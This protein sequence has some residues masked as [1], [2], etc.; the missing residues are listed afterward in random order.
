MLT[1]LHPA[2]AGPNVVTSSAD[3]GIFG[4]HPATCFKIAEVADCLF[5][6]PGPKRIVSYAE[7]IVFGATRETKD[8]HYS[9]PLDGQLEGFPN[10][11]KHVALC[12]A[13]RVTLINGSAQRS[14]LCLVFPLLPFQCPQGSPHHLAGVFV[15][16]GLNLL[17]NEAIKFVGQI[18]ISR[19]HNDPS[20]L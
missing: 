16:A 2:Q 10:A 18:D 9:A 11:R 17:Q 15:A 8:N 14:K 6:A 12:G 13:T 20:G 1:A 5:S 7:Q 4:K 19:R 3:R